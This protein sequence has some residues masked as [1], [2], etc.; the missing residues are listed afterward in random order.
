MSKAYG[1]VWTTGLMHKL[2][3]SGILDSSLVLPA[4]YYT[5]RKFRVTMVGTFSE[6]KPISAGVP[7]GAFLAPLLYNIYA[8]DIP[9]RSGIEISH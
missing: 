9:R 4:S 2:H 1:T 7:Q 8:A 3:A 5:D 6:W